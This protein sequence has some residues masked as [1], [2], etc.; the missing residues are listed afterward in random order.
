VTTSDWVHH[1]YCDCLECSKAWAHAEAARLNK[2]EKWKHGGG[3]TIEQPISFSAGEERT[4]SATGGQKGVKP[5]ALDQ[6]P[7]VALRELG[8]VF[9]FGA[10]KY[11]RDNWKNEYEWSKNYASALRHLTAWWQGEDKDPESDL[12]H[13]AHAM[14]H[15][16][17]L[18]WFQRQARY[19]EFDD[20][21]KG[22]AWK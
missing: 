2:I 17:V 12:S 20:R 13:L 18:Y 21:P 9:A 19:P 15:M 8:R 22:E 5:E 6:I 14:W 10:A 11:E 4:T 3:D 1:P 16:V 7:V